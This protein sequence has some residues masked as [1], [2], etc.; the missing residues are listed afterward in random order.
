MISMICLLGLELKHSYLLAFLYLHGNIF[1]QII[2]SIQ[3]QVMVEYGC[4]I[5]HILMVDILP[6]PSVHGAMN[7][8]NAGNCLF[9]LFWALTFVFSNIA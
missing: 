7:E 2:S 1:V 5:K 4:K 6:D 8:I 9:C 3:Y